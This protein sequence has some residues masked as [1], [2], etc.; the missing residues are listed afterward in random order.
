MPHCKDVLGIYTWKG[1][2]YSMFWG[3]T[4]EEGIKGKLGAIKP[5]VFTYSQVKASNSELCGISI[6]F[7][8]GGL[9][10][11]LRRAKTVNVKGYI[12]SHC[13][14]R[15]GFKFTQIPE[16]LKYTY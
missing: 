4:L 9:Q 3:K 10:L 12:N 15:R 14:M 16:K 13:G 2:N 11:I 5:F 8:T 7:A 6:H 1:S